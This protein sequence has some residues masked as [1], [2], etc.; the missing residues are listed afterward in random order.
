V[1]QKSNK[2]PTVKNGNIQQKYKPSPITI[3]GVKHFDKLK[4][5]LTREEPTGDE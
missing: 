3:K 1:A 5:L 4:Q 2:N